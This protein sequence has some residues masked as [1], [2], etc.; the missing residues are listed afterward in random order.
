MLLSLWR[1]RKTWWCWEQSFL[2]PLSPGCQI[3]LRQT[4]PP[5][6][7]GKAISVV[8]ASRAKGFCNWLQHLPAVILWDS[9]DPVELPKQGMW[10]MVLLS[11]Y[12]WEQTREKDGDLNCSWMKCGYMETFSLSHIYNLQIPHE[13]SFCDYLGKKKKNRLLSYYYF[14]K[15]L[16]SYAR[17]MRKQWRLQ[18]AIYQI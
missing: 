7:L 10:N 11:A 4:T 8:S 14:F 15:Q 13:H 5:F 1:V 18:K 6:T 3:L 17:N 16:K 12:A 9:I 2:P